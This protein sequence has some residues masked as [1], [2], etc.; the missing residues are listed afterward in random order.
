MIRVDPQVTVVGA[1]CSW[2][3]FWCVHIF[4]KISDD[5]EWEE[6]DG[7]FYVWIGCFVLWSYNTLDNVDGKLARCAARYPIGAR[8]PTGGAHCLL[9]LAGTAG[10]VPRSAK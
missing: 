6:Q 3:G 7:M 5:G 2:G 1:L 10:W 8:W 4:R 9:L